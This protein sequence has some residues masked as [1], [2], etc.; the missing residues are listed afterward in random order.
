MTEMKFFN[1]LY[2]LHWLN[3]FIIFIY[4]YLEDYIEFLWF[5]QN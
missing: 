5:I 3:L 4:N 1:N 2:L